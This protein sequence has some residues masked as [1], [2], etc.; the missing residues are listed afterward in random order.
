M[1]RAARVDLTA[2]N[3][4]A[5]AQNNCVL[6][7]QLHELGVPG[8]TVAYRTRPTGGPW[9]RLLPGTVLLHRGT[10]TPDELATAGLLYAG[11]GA[12]LTGLTSLRL[13]GLRRL[14][15]TGQVHVLI[16]DERRRASTGFVVCERTRRMPAQHDARAMAC[17]PLSR[18]LVDASRHLEV[19]S[20]VRA[21]TAEA[22]QR[23]LCKEQDL[24]DEIRL[25]Q[26]RRTAGIR[27]VGHE[28]VGGIRS[29]MEAGVRQ[30]LLDAGFP[31]ALW[32]HDILTSAGELIGCPDAWFDDVGLALEVD[33]REWH[34]DPQGWERTQAKRARFARFGIPTLP[35]TP[36]R[37]YLE[38]GD[39]AA[40][41][42]GALRQARANPR[43]DV[44]AVMRSQ[45]A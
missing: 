27:L 24:L 8:S 2:L 41:I 1:P 22:V 21:M 13:Q 10:P 12:M 19:L 20:T 15:P 38:R 45:A 43:P 31:P 18:A 6:L 33:S 7:S 37:F 35:I 32:N 17:A 40:D 29:A 28:I 39:L 30:F 44:I 25:G 9:R 4:L 3:A 23:R 16:P 11:D 36:K 34:L 14:P 42:H 26:R 5:S